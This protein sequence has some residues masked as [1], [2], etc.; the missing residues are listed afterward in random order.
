MLLW[1]ELCVNTLHGATRA[2]SLLIQPLDLPR[3]LASDRKLTEYSIG[4]QY[5]GTD[6]SK[7]IPSYHRGENPV[8]GFPIWRFVAGSGIF[9]LRA[10]CGIF[11]L[12]RIDDLIENHFSQGQNSLCTFDRGS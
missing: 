5:H 1:L 7:A 10:S 8:S 11:F 4:Q 9:F 6:C 12:S 3:S 2:S